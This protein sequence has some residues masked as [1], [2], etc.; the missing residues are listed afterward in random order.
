MTEYNEKHR[1][2]L[3]EKIA[4]FNTLITQLYQEKDA[5][6]CRIVDIDNMIES[7]EQEIIILGE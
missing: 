3:N 7:Y 6:N 4:E 1:A 5:L 2:V